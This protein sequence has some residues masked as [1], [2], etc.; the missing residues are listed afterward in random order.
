MRSA[1]A[2]TTL[3]LS[4]LSVA[5]APAQPP[6][7]P[8][9]KDPSPAHARPVRP[10]VAMIQPGIGLADIGF[11]GPPGLTDIVLVLPAAEP[12]AT[13]LR[14]PLDRADGARIRVMTGRPGAE[15]RFEYTSGGERRR[16]EMFRLGE[17]SAAPPAWAMGAVW[18]QIFPERYRNG[19]PLNDPRGPDVYPMQW[20]ADWYA[21]DS[22]EE[23]AWR[24]RTRRAADAPIPSRPGGPLYHW[25]YD[26]RY[27]GDLQGIAEKLDELKDLGVTAVYLNPIFQAFSSHKYDATDHRHID[28]NLA[29]PE[30]AGRPPEPWA[31]IE[32][33]TEDPATWTWTPADRYFI[34]VFLPECRRRGLRVMLDGVWNHCGR[35]HFAFQDVMKNGERS[36]YKDWFTCTFDS[37]GKLK[38]WKAWDGPSG[39]LPAFRQTPEGDL[40]EPVKQYVFG[41]TRRWMDPDGDGDPSDGVD[42]WRLD[43]AKDVG[44]AFWR[45]W[46]THV[47]SINAEAILIG[48]IWEPAPDYLKGDVFD[49]LMNYP[50]A[51]GMTDWLAVNPER[52][53]HGKLGKQLSSTA[54]LL[55]QN[56]LAS[57]DTDRY[58]SMLWNPGR[59]YDRGNSIQNGD[60]DYKAG[61]PPADIYRLSIL[62]VAV[63]AMY[64]G[65]P[66]IYYGDEWGMWGA[67]DP[68]CRK[69]VPWPDK[70]ANANPDEAVMP[71]IRSQYRTWLRLRQDPT[72]GP[73]LRY[74]SVRS[75]DTDSD[76]VFAFERSLNGAS[77]L[78][79][80]NAGPQPIR[81]LQLKADWGERCRARLAEDDQVP[82]LGT[83]WWYIPARREGN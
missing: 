39:W 10:S 7:T 45:G 38:T 2:L 51:F 31:P 21:V 26:R 42:G 15:Y 6:E 3:A 22:A 33:E 50:F 4:L 16:T 24:T 70:G 5:A 9:P 43:V 30:E 71:E 27:G 59:E 12:G 67:D 61:K 34:D 57:H 44:M 14:I 78:A 74:G 73:I 48:E 68:T 17:D 46:R 63:Q 40:V 28:V 35:K 80:I 36:R 37:Q 77:I 79:I 64:L 52:M 66:L 13:E 1:T 23:A 55:Q 56:L 62:G 75:I 19:N 18:Y 65:S 8:V 54:G 25:I 83:R 29:W 82:A 53:K 60:K 47:K 11:D 69:P 49:A 20:T 58:V 76:R 32:S 81:A 72:A 41:V